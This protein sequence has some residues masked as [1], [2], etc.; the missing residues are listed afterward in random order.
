M[1]L[2]YWIIKQIILRNSSSKFA[3]DYY[4]LI[5]ICTTNFKTF[6]KGP[7]GLGKISQFVMTK[8]DIDIQPIKVVVA[9]DFF[10]N[11]QRTIIIFQCSWI[12]FQFKINKPDIIQAY[13]HSFLISLCLTQNQYLKIY[14]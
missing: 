12:V 13:A 9:V 6:S 5:T 10:L 14:F 7:V 2:G 11:V 4:L 3:F 1:R 8:P